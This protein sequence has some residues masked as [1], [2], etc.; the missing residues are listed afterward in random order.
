MRTGRRR[1]SDARANRAALLDAA[2]RVVLRD[3]YAVPLDKIAAE[4]GV[5]VATLYRNF[6]DR[7]ELIAAVVDRSY[8][9]VAELARS[10]ARSSAEPLDALGGFFASVLEHRHRLVLPLLGGPAVTGRINPHSFEISTALQSV[11][12]RGIANGTVRADVGAPDIMVAGA[13]LAQPQL[14]PQAWEVAARRIATLL[15]DGLRA[16]PDQR[17]LPLTFTREEFSA[18]ITDHPKAP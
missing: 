12:Q 14:P 16:Q 8:E 2:A 5:G 3:G 17:P 6:A 11:I 18:A 1:R 10:A 15:L 9:L 13:M 7:D 4:A